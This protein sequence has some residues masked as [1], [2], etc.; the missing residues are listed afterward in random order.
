MAGVLPASPVL[1]K[2][3]SLISFLGIR[4]SPK[5]AHAL[6]VQYWTLLA[7][8]RMLQQLSRPKAGCELNRGVNL[9][10]SY[11]FADMHEEIV[12]HPKD[13]P[14]PLKPDDDGT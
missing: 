7:G 10:K 14:S 2:K 13:N 4:I 8:V 5:Q 1:G 6:W 9:G 12:V 11:I 3:Q